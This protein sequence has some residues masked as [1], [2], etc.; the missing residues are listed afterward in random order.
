[1]KFGRVDFEV[2]DMRVD[3]RTNR[4]KTDTSQYFASL[5]GRSKVTS[6]SAQFAMRIASTYFV[7]SADVIISA[8]LLSAYRKNAVAVKVAAV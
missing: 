3:W 5:S 6:K 2:R 4:Q 1:V 8:G 7:K